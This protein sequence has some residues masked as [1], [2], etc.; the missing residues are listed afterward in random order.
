MSSAANSS[1]ASQCFPDTHELFGFVVKVGAIKAAK[2]YA[3]PSI[4]TGSKAYY[5][6]GEGARL[7]GTGGL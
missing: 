6:S 5:L 3:R 2:K 1:R 4:S 7:L